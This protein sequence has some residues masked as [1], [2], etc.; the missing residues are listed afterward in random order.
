MDKCI[1]CRFE[2]DNC[3]VSVTGS[4]EED[5]G[6]KDV[7]DWLLP[8]VLVPSFWISV[9]GVGFLVSVSA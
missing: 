1:R 2:V 7:E 3:I 9:C 6:E 8:D 4:W 5:A